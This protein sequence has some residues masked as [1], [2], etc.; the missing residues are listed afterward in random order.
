MRAKK[1]KEA[2]APAARWPEVAQAELA[3]LVLE[4]DA[5]LGAGIY[6]ATKAELDGIDGG[7]SDRDCDIR[8]A[9]WDEARN[10]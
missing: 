1:L 6:R 8:H 2:L 9:A 4:I 3:E 10:E 5:E 7:R